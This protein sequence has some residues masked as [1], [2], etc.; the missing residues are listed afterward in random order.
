MNRIHFPIIPNEII[1]QHLLIKNNGDVAHLKV[2]I[3]N[4]MHQKYVVS[5]YIRY[6]VIKYIY[7]CIHV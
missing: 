1:V 5:Y 2:E 7:R 3:L 4:M 6:V